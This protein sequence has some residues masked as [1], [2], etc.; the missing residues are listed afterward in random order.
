MLILILVVFVCIFQFCI[1]CFVVEINLSLLSL[2]HCTKI[3]KQNVLK[4]VGCMAL[5]RSD[6]RLPAS[7]TLAVH[8]YPLGTQDTNDSS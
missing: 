5:I 7:L 2:H 3:E 8:V 6:G 4:K 1:T